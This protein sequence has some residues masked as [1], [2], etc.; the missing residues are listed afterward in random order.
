MIRNNL[1]GIDPFASDVEKGL[2]KK[3]KS[4][5]SKYFYDENGSQ[6]FTEIMNLPEYYLTN[7]ET[8]IFETHK[9]KITERYNGKIVFVELGAGD[10]TKTRILLEKLIEKEKIHKYVPLDISVKALDL[11]KENLSDFYSN[12]SIQPIEIDFLAEL[13]ELHFPNHRLVVAYL[14]SSLGNLT[15]QGSIRFLKKINSIL[16][17]GDEVFLGLDL[18]KDLILIKDAYDDMNGITAKFNLNLLKR[19]NVQLGANFN[20][21]SFFHHASYNAKEKAMHSHVISKIEQEI[22]FKSLEKTFHFNQY[23]SIFLERSCKYSMSDILHMAHLS[24]F[25]VT[26]HFKDQNGWFMNV[27]FKKIKEV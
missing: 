14:G 5:S 21:E 27:F 8:E 16:K 12:L 2:S 26:D 24:G 22:Y 18:I 6:I 7:S 1:Y 25:E 11:L 23:E 15:A 13:P 17:P 19:M 9:N 3:H 4:I 10:A 20:L